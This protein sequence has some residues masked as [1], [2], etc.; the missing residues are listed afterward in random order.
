MGYDTGAFIANL[1]LAYCSQDGHD[2]DERRDGYREWILETVRDFWT[3]FEAGFLALWRKGGTGD[4]F[5]AGLFGD[6]AGAAALDEFRRVTM[7]RL[8]ADTLGHG[9][10][11]MIRRI[12]GLAHVEDLESIADPDLRARCERRALAMARDLMIRRRRI[13]SIE[14]VLGL[15]RAARREF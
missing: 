11:K 12:L 13:E 2:P 4:A 3:R 10:A 7:R 5:T 1:L 9:A 15:A 8:F 6:A 14:D